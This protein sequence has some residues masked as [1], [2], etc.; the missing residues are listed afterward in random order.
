M[1]KVTSSLHCVVPNEIEN[2]VEE[3]AQLL[4]KKGRLSGN[5][6]IE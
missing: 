1:P 5:A 4:V 6:K 3:M 2:E